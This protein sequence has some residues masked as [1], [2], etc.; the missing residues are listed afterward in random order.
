MSNLYNKNVTLLFKDTP[1]LVF[2]AFFSLLTKKKITP[3]F[4]KSTLLT[5][6]KNLFFQ[7][8]SSKA[9]HFSIKS[10]SSL[11]FKT[12]ENETILPSTPHTYFHKRLNSIISFLQLHDPTKT[13]PPPSH[14]SVVIQNITNHSTT[15]SD[16]LAILKFP[17]PLTYPLLSTYK[18]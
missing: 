18:I 3:S 17:L 16:V 8:N 2:T 1:S 6:P 12:T 14:C 5:P 13:T 4:P 9:A 11:S 15:L 7:P 10:S